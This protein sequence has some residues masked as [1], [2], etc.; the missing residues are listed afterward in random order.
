[1][2]SLSSTTSITTGDGRMVESTSARVE[3]STTMRPTSAAISTDRTE[4]HRELQKEKRKQATLTSV[5]FR[6][7]VTRRLQLCQLRG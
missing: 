4:D 5:D 2:Q 3:A 7:K 1:M 6:R